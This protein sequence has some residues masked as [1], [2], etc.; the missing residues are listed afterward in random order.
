MIFCFLGKFGSVEARCRPRSGL[1]LQ[2]LPPCLPL[3]QL[4]PLGIGHC[5]NPTCNIC[6]GSGGCE[7]CDGL[8]PHIPKITFPTTENT[9]FH[10]N[11]KGCIFFLFSDPFLFLSFLIFS[12]FR[13]CTRPSAT[14]S[15]HKFLLFLIKDFLV[16]CNELASTPALPMLPSAL[17]FGSGLKSGET[18]ILLPAKAVHILLL[19]TESKRRLSQVPLIYFFQLP[20]GGSTTAFL[21]LPLTCLSICAN[22]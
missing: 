5:T 19:D 7:K 4:F 6:V 2:E 15:S 22:D 9:Y 3:F 14:F 17:F 10:I 20:K 16:H 12:F 1:T 18:R 21:C 13:P 11:S 8:V